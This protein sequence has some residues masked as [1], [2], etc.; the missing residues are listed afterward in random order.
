MKFSTK[1]SDAVHIMVFIAL[2]PKSN[3]SSASI[4]E[5][6]M[7]NAGFVRQIMSKLKQAGLIS[8]TKGHPKPVISYPLPQITL[9]DIYRA[10]EGE[11]PLLH[12]DTHTNPSCGVGVNIQLALK[13]YYNEIQECAEEKM[14]Q[15]TLQQIVDSYYIKIEHNDLPFSSLLD[16]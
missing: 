1:L 7:T 4:A 5:S 13:D 16:K 6:I 2:N 9:F 10:V 12:L 15:I 8:S 3:L 11:K 14:K